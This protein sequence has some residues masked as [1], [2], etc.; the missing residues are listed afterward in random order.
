MQNK[1]TRNPTNKEQELIIELA[2]DISEL[3][4]ARRIPVEISLTAG[5]RFISAS[6]VSM[7]LARGLDPKKY[8]DITL[9]LLRK[10]MLADLEHLKEHVA[11]RIKELETEFEKEF[12]I[13]MPDDLRQALTRSIT[14]AE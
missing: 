10:I 13:E 2:S 8:M 3:M 9:D 14:D 1:A 7:I 6:T 5:V 12:G 11:E 4:K